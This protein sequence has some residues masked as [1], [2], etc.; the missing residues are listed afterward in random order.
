MTRRL[1]ILLGV[2]ALTA[3]A[4]GGG[5]AWNSGTGPT[6]GSDTPDVAGACLANDP[7]C[8]DI[9]DPN[10]DPN[11]PS[12]ASDEPITPSTTLSVTELLAV[13]SIDGPF[14]VTGYLFVDADGHA[15]L[16]EAIAESY[17]PQ[18]GGQS[19]DV[20]GD[21]PADVDLTADQGVQWSDNPVDLEGTFDGTTFTTA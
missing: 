10:A 6:D 14:V 21:I 19:I 17:P 7:D 20:A 5:D 2:L 12:D 18:C 13:G 11:A 16:C 8:K 9:G 4:C 15:V 1:L 3:A